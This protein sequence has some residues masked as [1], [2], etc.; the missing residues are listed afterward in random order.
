MDDL[1]VKL[2]DREGARTS[3]S[4]SMAVAQNQCPADRCDTIIGDM[5]AELAE[6]VRRTGGGPRVSAPPSRRGAQLDPGV[7][8]EPLPSSGLMGRAAVAVL[9][10]QAAL[11]L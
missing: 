7:H 2:F 3:G 6:D 11:C 4:T 9:G 5:E 1:G 10:G 8:P